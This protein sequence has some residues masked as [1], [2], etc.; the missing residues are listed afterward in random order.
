[1]G[2]VPTIRCQLKRAKYR[3]A[4]TVKIA[5]HICIAK[6]QHL[7]IQP[8]QRRITFEIRQNIMGVTIHFDDQTFL[9]TKE[10]G[11][12]G[13]DHRLPTEFMTAQLGAGQSGPETLF[14]FSRITAHVM[15][16]PVQLSQTL[17]R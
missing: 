7:K 15:S 14:R 17:N 5:D 6:V 10:I 2:A 13:T 3:F 4:H 8:V 11:N 16:E 12:E 1:M 9:R